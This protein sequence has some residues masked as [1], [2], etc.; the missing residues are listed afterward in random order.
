[1]RDIKHQ[2][3]VGLS[4]AGVSA[5]FITFLGLF[6]AL[7]A[8]FQISQG[9]FVSAGCAM[10]ISGFLDMLDGTVARL[11][12]NL[13]Y[14]GG[15]L[16]SV[17]DRYG[18]AFL[19]GGVMYYCAT[20]GSIMYFF[21]AFSALVA[22]FGVSYVRARAECEIENCRVGFWERGERIVVLAAGLLMQNLPVAIWILGTLPHF[23][24]IYRLLYAKEPLDFSNRARANTFSLK[25]FFLD[26]RRRTLFYT[27]K[28]IFL[29]LLMLIWRPSL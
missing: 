10:L 1:M 24:V 14:F 29:A 4:E 6:V 16:D 20:E 23:S 26:T 3:A 13:H 25:D 7:I 8:G 22:A 11:Q 2:I 17:L 21:L 18:D 19:Y 15:I 12:E 9:R 27:L 5:N 28:C